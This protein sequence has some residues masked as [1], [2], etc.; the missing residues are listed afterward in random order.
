M[1]ASMLKLLSIVSLLAGFGDSRSNELRPN[2]GYPA[3]V[4]VWQVFSKPFPE[5]LLT[6]EG[7]G[8]LTGPRR[9]L[10]EQDF[11][12]IHSQFLNH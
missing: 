5:Y 4:N 2:M 10:L 7:A 12:I 9:P 8:R 6:F 3:G 1:F 11:K